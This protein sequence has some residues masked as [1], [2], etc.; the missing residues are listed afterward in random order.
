MKFKILFLLVWPVMIAMPAYS[1]LPEKAEDI[2]PLLTGEMIPDAV[3]TSPDGSIHQVSELISEKPTVFLFYRG[4]WCPYCNAHL[5]E[6]QSAETEIIELGYQIIAISPDSPENLLITDKKLKL[7]YGLFSDA[8]G[9]F[10]K[11][12]GIAFYAPEKYSAM[13]LGKSEGQNEG[14]LPVPSVFLVDTTGKIIFEYI[15]PDY[16]TRLT[17]GLLLSVLKELKTSTQK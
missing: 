5:A 16:R 8:D 3:L 6:I 12:L 2:S 10:I 17:A 14:F 13:L 4:G 11:A 9:A 15:N 1:Q 7:N